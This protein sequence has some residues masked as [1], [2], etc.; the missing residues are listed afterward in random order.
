M[1]KLIILH[2][3]FLCVVIPG[4]RMSV[5]PKSCSLRQTGLAAGLFFDT[6]NAGKKN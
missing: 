6:G 1:P 2:G 5:I 3:A 4:L